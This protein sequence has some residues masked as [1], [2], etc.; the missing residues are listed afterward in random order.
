[1][2]KRFKLRRAYKRY[3]KL[4]NSATNGVSALSYL[5]AAEVTRRELETL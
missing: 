4:F 5:M 2:F 1:M 3:I